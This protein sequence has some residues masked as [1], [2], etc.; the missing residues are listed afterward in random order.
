MVSSAVCGFLLGRR[1]GRLPAKPVAPDFPPE[2]TCQVGCAWFSAWDPPVKSVAH[3]NRLGLA[4]IFVFR[5]IRD[6]AIS[7]NQAIWVTNTQIVTHISFFV[8]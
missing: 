6:S 2:G 5:R 7:T 3:D 4:I 1:V 8:G